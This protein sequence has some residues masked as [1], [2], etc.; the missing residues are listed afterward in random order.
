MEE[1]EQV[2]ET[3]SPMMRAMAPGLSA[4]FG[5]FLRGG[6]DRKNLEADR[7]ALN[8]MLQTGMTNFRYR[9]LAMEFESFADAHNE[10]IERLVTNVRD[11]MIKAESIVDWSKVDL[12]K[13]SPEF[14]YRWIQETQNVREETLQDLWARLLAGELESPNS[15]SNDIMSIARDL[16]RELSANFQILCSV[17]LYSGTRP[18]VVVGCGNPGE[19]SLKPYG[20]S[21]DILMDLAHHR[22]INNDMN[23]HIN[24]NSDA[25]REGAV[26]PV[27]HAGRSMML[28]RSDLN[29]EVSQIK[30]VLFTRAGK[31]LFR[32]VE[33]IPT[34]EYSR[35]MVETLEADG[36]SVNYVN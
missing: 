18:I 12:E 7:V 14:R 19:D 1:L 2:A 10:E 27:S 25:L 36:W 16:N 26:I 6:Q 33:R 4:A 8:E 23:T 15:V 29:A 11:I 3:A 32:V 5:T 31:E 13:F 21:Y 20:L 30:G 17:A 28:R 34:P 22:L 35:K 24:Y 9:G